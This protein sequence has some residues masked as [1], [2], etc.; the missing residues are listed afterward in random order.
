M[1][2]NLMKINLY[3]SLFFLLISLTAL[4]CKKDSEPAPA[5]LVGTWTYVTV[6]TR[7]TVKATG[8]QTT[9]TDTYTPNG[10]KVTFGADGLASEAFQGTVNS[11]GTYTYVGTTLT[12]N[13]GPYYS[14]LGNV[15]TVTS[16][17]SNALVFTV[18][19]VD[20]YA[21]YFRTYNLTR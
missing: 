1:I 6:T 2:L 11:T 13:G 20:S 8:A 14:G 4:S 7:T 9:K 16:L 12:R 15:Y 5:S 3:K 21:T 10:L 18:T 19:D 17:T